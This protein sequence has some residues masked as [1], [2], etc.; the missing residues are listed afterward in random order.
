MVYTYVK[1]EKTIEDAPQL[2]TYIDN[3]LGMIHFVGHSSSPYWDVNIGKP[4]EYTN[5][6]KYPAIIASSC[7]VGNIH[8]KVEGV[9]KRSM[10][11][12][13]VLADNCGSISFMAPV[14]LGFLYEMDTYMKEF[15]KMFS[16]ERYGEPIGSIMKDICPLL[17][18]DCSKYRPIGLTALT[19]T[20]AGD[21]AIKLGHFDTPRICHG[22]QFGFLYA[23]SYE[24]Q[25][26]F[27]CCQYCRL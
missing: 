3:G 22:T 13:Y 15:Y 14:Y 11:V 9:D 12:D 18:S 19:Y 4:E 8:E 24:C 21:P 5:E 7:F 1:S 23:Q 27:F 25:C 10:S 6:G 2:K 26:R 17:Y 20:Y 16:K